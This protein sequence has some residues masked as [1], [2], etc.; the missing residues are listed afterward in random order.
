MGAKARAASPQGDCFAVS[1]WSLQPTNRLR[2]S[3]CI[4]LAY[5][6]F[7]CLRLALLG[8]GSVQYSLRDNCSI[9]LWPALQVFSSVLDYRKYYGAAVSQASQFLVLQYAQDPSTSEEER[10]TQPSCS[11]HRLGFDAIREKPNPTQARKFIWMLSPSTF[12]R[13]K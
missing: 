10:P 9:G 6:D 11:F 13:L 5:H 2:R 1:T 12:C 7:Y 4:C 3:F 8:M